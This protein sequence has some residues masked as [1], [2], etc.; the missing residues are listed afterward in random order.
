METSTHSP[1]VTTNPT[2]IKKSQLFRYEN[3]WLHQAGFHEILVQEWSIG[4]HQGDCTKK[5]YNK[6]RSPKRLVI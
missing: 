1:L 5:T 2:S 3:F 6:I 4:H